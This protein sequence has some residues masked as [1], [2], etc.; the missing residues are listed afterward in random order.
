MN[1]T[2]TGASGFIGRKLARRLLD[3]NALIDKNGREQRIE[4]LI[5]FDVVGGPDE[6][7]DDPRVALVTGDITDLAAIEKAIPSDTDTVFHLAAVVSA[8]AEENFDLGM[9]VNLDATRQI[10][11]ISRRHGTRPKVVFASSC[12]AFG[13]DVPGVITDMTAR[14]PGTSYG[15]QKVIGELLVNDYSRKQFVD[16]RA[17]RFPTVVVRPGK[18]NK[19][20]S[21]FA[22]S[23]IRE[24]LQ[25]ERAVCPVTPGS[26]M[27]LAS[28]RTIVEN[29]LRAHNLDETEWGPSRE[30]TLPGFTLT[31]REMVDA[32]ERVAGKTVVDRIDW[33][34]D[35]FIQA[36]VS[37]WPPEF[38][39]AKATNLGLVRDNSMDEVILGFIEDELDGVFAA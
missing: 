7:S 34:P 10:L 3:A 11:E 6:L 39:T 37:G 38:E 25:G 22:S 14:T 9:A 27:F 15:T 1:V 26:R 29:V 33:Q 16:G 28:P 8:G 19:A 18:P 32:L 4:R 13:G 20:A 12:A 24:P 23:I 2:I 36:I 5:L 30:V 31:I 17:L 21:T 35:T